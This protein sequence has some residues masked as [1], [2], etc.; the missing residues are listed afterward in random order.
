[1]TNLIE[2]RKKLESLLKRKEES[3]RSNHLGKPSVN[4]GAYHASHREIHEIYLQ[5]AEVCRE[6]GDPIPIK[7]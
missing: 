5:L 6:L 4:E 7:F 1:M 2:Q 3:H